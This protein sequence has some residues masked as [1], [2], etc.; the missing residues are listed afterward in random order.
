MKAKKKKKKK[1]E[2]KI[3]IQTL[4]HI[5]MFTILFIIY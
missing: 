2:V 5:K 3:R 4:W 1:W